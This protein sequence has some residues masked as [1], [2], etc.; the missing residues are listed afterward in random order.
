MSQ[1]AII[2]KAFLLFFLINNATLHQEFEDTG[3]ALPFWH[4]FLLSSDLVCFVCNLVHDDI[5]V[6]LLFKP[7]YFMVIKNDPHEI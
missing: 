3:N 5:I 7:N 6:C 1:I 4:F 2:P